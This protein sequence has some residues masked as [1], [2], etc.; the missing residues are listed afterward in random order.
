MSYDIHVISKHWFLCKIS[1][2]LILY[3]KKTS[4]EFQN[5]T[6][7]YSFKSRLSHFAEYIYRRYMWHL[8]LL[9]E[10]LLLDKTRNPSYVF[11]ECTMNTSLS[12]TFLV[13]Q[14]Q[15]SSNEKDFIK[16]CSSSFLCILD[17]IEIKRGRFRNFR[18]CSH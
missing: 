12:S 4:Q 3:F 7:F 1:N 17:A 8:L 6:R 11:L 10:T 5:S 2:I 13:H 18:E 15:C 16:D 9:N 14:L